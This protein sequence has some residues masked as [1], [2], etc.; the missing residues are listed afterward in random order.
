MS[1]FPFE[2]LILTCR[3]NVSADKE[4]GLSASEHGCVFEILVVLETKNLALSQLVL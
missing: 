4:S 1:V 3:R 2:K